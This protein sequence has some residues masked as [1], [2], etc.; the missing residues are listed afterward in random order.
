MI[1]EFKTFRELTAPGYFNF[2]GTQKPITAKISEWFNSIT[3]V[4]ADQVDLYD[5]YFRLWA[6][7][8]YSGTT[9]S[10]TPYIAYLLNKW[11]IGWFT[12]TDAQAAALIA[13]VSRGY[14]ESSS[15]NFNYFFS[16]M[17]APPF[18][19]L[20]GTPQITSGTQIPTKFAETLI[21]FSSAVSL[22]ATP[23]PQTYTARD[24]A[25]PSGWALLATTSTYYSRGY[26]TSGGTVITWMTPKSTSLVTPFYDVANIASLPVSPATASLSGVE[27]DG[28]GDVGAIYYYDGAVWR[29]TTTPNINQGLVSPEGLFPTP[30]PRAVF[31]PASMGSSITSQTPPPA[32][33]GSQGYGMYAGMGPDILKAREIDLIFDLTNAGYANLGIIINLLRRIKPTLNKLLV[34]YTIEGDEGTITELEIKDSGSIA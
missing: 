28:T 26:L 13:F 23:S 22:P 8:D 1:A 21:I 31:A 30:L 10:R 14:L 3:S 2:S 20:D 5:S 12:G 25:A 29:K 32:D 16:V 9:I 34:L 4:W 27:D 17:I 33:G 6:S 7:K 15:A 11:G 24:W 18:E 19:W